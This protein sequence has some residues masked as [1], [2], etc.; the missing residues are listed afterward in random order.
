MI[1]AYIG[2]ALHQSAQPL[3]IFT[4]LC[5]LAT[6]KDA[7]VGNWPGINTR[8]SGTTTIRAAIPQAFRE[9]VL[10]KDVLRIWMAMRMPQTL[11]GIQ[12]ITA[13]PSSRS[14][15][16]DAKGH[17]QPTPW[18]PRKQMIYKVLIGIALI[19]VVLAA[20]S[21]YFGA[22]FHPITYLPMAVLLVALTIQLGHWARD[23]LD[24][25]Q[26]HGRLRYMSAVEVS[27]IELEIRHATLQHMPQEAKG[28]SKIRKACH[29]ILVEMKSTH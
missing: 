14:H 19:W 27:T 21:W 18:L 10:A 26:R 6:N 12:S 20:I 2:L 17:A 22:P 3:A 16:L 5:A 29:T 15:T 28:D 24:A 8:W 25:T 4:K 13:P 9:M 11:K 1:R 7:K 23:W